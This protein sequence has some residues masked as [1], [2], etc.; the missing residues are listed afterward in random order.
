MDYSILSQF[1]ESVF[2]VFIYGY[3]IYLI[4]FLWCLI[5]MTIQFIFLTLTKTQKKSNSVI[6]IVF[7]QGIIT[8]IGCYL[9]MII[10]DIYTTLKFN[11]NNTELINQQFIT[12]N[13]LT[14]G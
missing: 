1:Y 4:N 8:S 12:D 2:P 14:V 10:S 11:W 13:I 7:T 6:M 5:P 3:I 9:Y